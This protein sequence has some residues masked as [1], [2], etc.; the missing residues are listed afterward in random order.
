M[1]APRFI[2]VHCS[3]TRA[4]QWVSAADIRRWHLARGWRDIGYHWV[5][6]RSGTL[7]AGRS[8]AC[9]GA[10]VR[11]HNRGNIGICLVG[12][13][14]ELGAPQDNFTEDQMLVLRDLII[15]LSARFSIDPVCVVGHRD[16]LSPEDPP[17]SC[18]CFDVGFWL[19]NT[20]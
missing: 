13:V 12:G 10:H 18:P 7:V 17:K 2:T 6:E 4:D 20:V 11:G 5:I 19:K 14:D 1:A 9:E 16:W 15:T 8:M 3:A